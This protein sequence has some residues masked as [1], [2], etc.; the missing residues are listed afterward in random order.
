MANKKVVFEREQGS[1]GL[2]IW[3]EELDGLTDVYF[4]V[5]HSGQD[6][7]PL[8]DGC[9]DGCLGVSTEARIVLAEATMEFFME[10]LG[11]VSVNDG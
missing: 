9:L 8:I 7:A 11:V 10:G 3:T 2:H 5:V 1:V 6:D 4:Q